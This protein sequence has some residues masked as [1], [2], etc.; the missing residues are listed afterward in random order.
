[1][2]T[3]RAAR[4][5]TSARVA[6]RAPVMFTRNYSPPD[7]KQEGATASSKG[8]SQREQA[9]EGQYIKKREVEKLKEAKARL[10]QAQAEVEAQ[11]KKVD[12]HK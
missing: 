4:S 7:V 3:A 9:E 8:F 2:L 11:Q 5:V 1:M 12:Q 6:L 10:E